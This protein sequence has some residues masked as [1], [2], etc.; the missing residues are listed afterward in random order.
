M[1]VARG[2]KKQLMP[3]PMAS[4]VMPTVAK[5]PSGVKVE[6]QNATRANTMKPKVATAWGPAVHVGPHDRP[7]PSR[8]D[9]ALRG[10]QAG[11]ERRVALV[12]LQP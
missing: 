2:R 1:M 11:I 8:E 10:G 3:M 9:A 12:V 7:Q 5:S 6:L 4:R